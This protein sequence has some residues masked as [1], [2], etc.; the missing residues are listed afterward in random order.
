VRRDTALP[1]PRCA[2]SIIRFTTAASGGRNRIL[3]SNPAST[4]GRDNNTV[5]MSYDEGQTWPVNRTVCATSASYS[6]LAIQCDRRIGV[7][8]ETGA[9]SGTVI[10][11]ATFNLEWLSQGRDSLGSGQ[12]AVFRSFSGKA[13]NETGSTVTGAVAAYNLAGKKVAVFAGGKIPGEFF[14]A[15]NTGV[16]IVTIRG[17][18]GKRCLRLFKCR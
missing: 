4:A 9:Y 13:A 16:C 2:A 5:K 7:L 8:Y 15:G 17:N 1:E 11:Y 12:T 3:F 6:D 18:P 10:H 14:A